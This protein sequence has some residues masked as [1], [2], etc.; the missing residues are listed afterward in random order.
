MKRRIHII[1][2]G[3]SNLASV[4]NGFRRLGEDAYISNRAAD[5][6]NASHV[7]LPG[8]GVCDVAMQRVRENGLFDILKNLEQ[9]VLGICVGLQQM[10]DFSEEGDVEGLGIFSG[11]SILFSNGDKPVPHMGWNEL[12][13]HK[14]SKLLKGLTPE[15]VYYVHSYF[16]PPDGYTVATSLYGH[17]SIAAV[18]EKDNFFGCQFHPE[19][20]GAYGH[21]IL[22][23]FTT[24]C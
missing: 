3:G 24:L 12:D 14:P 11:A 5:I 19:R 2:C 8:V 16:I 20:S 1:D 17:Q 22:Q 18:V 9:P 15:H 10:Y 4:V 6:K 21:K 7:V 13:I 23:N